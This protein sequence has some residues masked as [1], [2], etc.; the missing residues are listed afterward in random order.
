MHG[1]I[2]RQGLDFVIA[3]HVLT[4]VHSVIG[5]LQHEVLLDG[6]SMICTREVEW[7]VAPEMCHGTHWQ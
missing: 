5:L 2:A 7:V 1:Q 6:G 3:P 4:R